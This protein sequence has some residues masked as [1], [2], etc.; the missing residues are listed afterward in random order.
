MISNS[1]HQSMIVSSGTKITASRTGDHITLWLDGG[2]STMQVTFYDAA[3]LLALSDAV[4]GDAVT[5]FIHDAH[6]DLAEE[7][8]PCAT[9]GHV[10][11]EVMF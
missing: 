3:T 2:M 1:T 4:T 10:A 5:E 9:C 8:A 7:T 11:T 6:L